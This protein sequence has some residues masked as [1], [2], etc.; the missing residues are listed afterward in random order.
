[1]QAGIK[2]YIYEAFNA[3]P[4]GML[5]P[6]NWVGLGFV[7]I[8]GFLNPGFWVLGAGLELGYLLVL[9]NNPRFQRVIKARI[10]HQTQQEQ[11]SKLQGLISQLEEEQQ[12]RYRNLEDRCRGILSQLAVA[13]D[14]AAAS[15]QGEGLRRL[16]WI[17]LRLLLT[18]QMI[19]HSLQESLGRGSKSIDIRINE[20]E[21]KLNVQALGENLRKSFQSQLDILRQRKEKQ[22]EA[23]EKLVFLE[24][25]LVRIQEQIE[26]LREQTVISTG[27]DVVSNR[28]DNIAE[29]LGD[30]TRWIKEQQEIYGGVEDLLEE[31]PP[32]SPVPIERQS[33]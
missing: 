9:S 22:N 24:A 18:R 25:E 11:Y 20:L 10:L 2:D 28:I 26:L 29:T 33:Q 32:L 31:P 1:M 13:N 12:Q 19:L 8:L 27:T 6:P 4:L 16:L 14:S 7:G 5:V 21:K 3:R 15:A 23:R 17:F 30:T